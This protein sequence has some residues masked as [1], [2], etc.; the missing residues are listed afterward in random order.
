MEYD[1]ES[2]FRGIL[3]EDS[4]K[5]LLCQ[6]VEAFRSVLKD[7]REKFMVLTT[8]ST[9]QPLF[10][11]PGLPNGLSVYS[12][13]YEALERESLITIEVTFSNQ[14]TKWIDIT[15]LGFL[16][17]KFLK[18]ENQDRGGNIADTMR[19][20][21]EMNP[22]QERCPKAYQR[23]FEADQLLWEE[24]SDNQ[25]TVIGHRCREA[26]QAFASA[27][28]DRYNPPEVD[29]DVKHPGKRI[30]TVI[31][32]FKRSLGKTKYDL[33]MKLVEYFGALSDLAQKLEHDGAAEKETITWE[34]ARLLVFQ[35]LVVLY[36]IDHAL[37]LCRPG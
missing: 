33:L 35:T 28:V 1:L 17:Y 5:V 3:L 26:L 14:G 11:H 10:K 8:L 23:W 24:E 29:S 12:G 16:Y 15:S 19:T 30:I 37:L 32:L 6:L 13:D 34:S 4:Q 2:K 31:D 25:C 27:L 18:R 22:F 7:R 9:L 21:L 20:Y 36:E